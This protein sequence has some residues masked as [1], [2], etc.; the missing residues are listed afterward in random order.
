MILVRDVFRLQFGKAR[1]AIA[2]WKE[3]L[4]IAREMGVMTDARLLT[5]L[6]GPDYYTL[7][8]ELTFP[9]LTEYEQDQEHTRAL[10][11]RSHLFRKVDSETVRSSLAHSPPIVRAAISINHTPCSLMRHS[12]CTGPSRKP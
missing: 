4:T 5:D 12:A 7:I 8:L 9:S 3:G 11:A 1:P 2:L 10:L 6:V